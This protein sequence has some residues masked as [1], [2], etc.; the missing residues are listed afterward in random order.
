MSD[1]HKVTMCGCRCDLCQAYTPNVQQKDRR[2]TL[3]QMWNKYYGLDPAVMDRCDGCRSSHPFDGECPVRKC[4]LKKG[5]P[6]CGD[7][8]E[9]PCGVFYQRCGSFPAEKKKDFDMDEYNAYILAYDNLTR[10][11]EYKI[12]LEPQE[13][14]IG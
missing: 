4:V 7:C 3:A 13:P 11:N 10:L 2:Q 5:L 14:A 6:H 1:A 9:F 8:G 12:K